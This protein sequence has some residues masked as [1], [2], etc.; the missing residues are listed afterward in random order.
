M[1]FFVQQMYLHA[2][3]SLQQYYFQQEWPSPVSLLAFTV[4]FQKKLK[5]IDPIVLITRRTEKIRC[6][7][8]QKKFPAK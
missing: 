6:E 7:D 2:W 3:C 4:H 5:S 1:F 8:K